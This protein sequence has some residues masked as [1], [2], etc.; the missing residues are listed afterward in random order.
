M[1][2]AR[3]AFGPLAH[4][5]VDPIERLLAGESRTVHTLEALLR[6]HPTWALRLVVGTDVLA[7]SEKW[8]RFERV[9]EL[10]PLI[11]LPRGDG[12]K[13]SPLPVISSTE[14]RRRLR[15]GVHADAD[16]LMPRAVLDLLD[17][18][19]VRALVNGS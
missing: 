8:Y 9:V 19:A 11:V 2:L 13:P 6:L 7:E 14:I 18:D 17:A 4:V 16:A 12:S 10:A 15:E 5:A 1:E 3:A